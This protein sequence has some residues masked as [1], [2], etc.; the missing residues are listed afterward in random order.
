MGGE[1]P[2]G[3][4][5]WQM[6]RQ[7]AESTGLPGVAP[8]DAG[9]TGQNYAGSLGA[10]LSRYKCSWDNH[11]DKFHSLLTARA[12][13]SC[14]QRA[15]RFLGAIYELHQAGLAPLVQLGQTLSAWSEEIVAMW[16]FTRNNGITEAFTTKWSS[17]TGKPTASVISKT[18]DFV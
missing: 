2:G 9:R 13:M 11:V 4:V 16:R 18:T 7:Y 8:H 5:L 3:K 14:K 1:R 17:S 6:L 10:S 12:A 15:P